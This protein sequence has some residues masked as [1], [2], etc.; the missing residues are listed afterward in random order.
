M[1]TEKALGKVNVLVN[2]AGVYKFAPIEA[3]SDEDFDWMFN[4]NVRGPLRTT[5]EAVKHFGETGGVI[6]NT[7]SVVSHTFG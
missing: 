3:Y 5:Q 1:E 6:I 7:G 4:T 2:N